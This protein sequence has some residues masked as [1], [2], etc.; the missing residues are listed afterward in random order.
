MV[1]GWGCS[2]SVVLAA[3]ASPLPRL[4]CQ[5]PPDPPPPTGVQALRGPVSFGPG[6]CW[7]SLS[8]AVGWAQA[9]GPTGVLISTS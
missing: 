3:A 1:L 6:L 9:P 7:D 5:N 8:A 2:R 4:L